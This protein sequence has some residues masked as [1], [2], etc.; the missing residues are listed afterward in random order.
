MGHYIVN[1]SGTS[2]P[3]YDFWTHEV[4]GT[5]NNRESYVT[6]PGADCDGRGIYFLNSAGQ[7][8]SGYITNYAG[9]TGWLTRPYYYIDGKKWFR[10]RYNLNFYNSAGQMI[11][12]DNGV[13]VVVKAGEFVWT[14]ECLAGNSMPYLMKVRQYRDYNTKQWI[15]F[16]EGYAFVDTGLTSYGSGGNYIGIQGNW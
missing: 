10:A 3:I 4:I 8:K 14:D 6:L 15:S 13:P 11:R 9:H 1:V 5:L 2:V 16:D 12:D 7:L